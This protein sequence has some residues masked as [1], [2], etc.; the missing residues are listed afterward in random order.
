M[1]WK[2]RLNA[3]IAS[4]LW[5]HSA[6]ESLMRARSVLESDATGVW[7]VWVI[8]PDWPSYSTQHGVFATVIK[9][10]VTLSLA[11][12]RMRYDGLLSAWCL[13]GLAGSSTHKIP[14]VQCMSMKALLFFSIRGLCHASQEQD[15]CLMIHF[16]LVLIYI[17]VNLRY[18]T[19]PVKQCDYCPLHLLYRQGKV[20]V[21]RMVQKRQC[22]TTEHF[23]WLQ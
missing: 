21:A 12:R 3:K 9:P 10:S 11:E 18:M 14:S 13:I 23:S 6:A 2:W 20:Q 5:T 7:S 19:A 8:R 22:L 1:R 15:Q 17:E 16:H 4:W